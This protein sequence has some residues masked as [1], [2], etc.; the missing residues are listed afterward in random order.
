MK[1]HSRVYL[2]CSAGVVSACV[3]TGRYSLFSD[4]EL[5]ALQNSLAAVSAVEF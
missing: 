5:K 4:T 2:G 1:D 3:G